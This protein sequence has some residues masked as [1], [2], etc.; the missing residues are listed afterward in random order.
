M[1]TGFLLGG[2]MAIWR[3]KKYGVKKMDVVYAACFAAGGGFLGAK[4][5]AILTFIPQMAAGK[6]S[7]LDLLTGGFVFYGGLIGGIGGLF[8]YVKIY[9]CKVI[10]YF[11]IFAPS[12]PLGHAVGR[13]GCFFA[14][15]CYGM[16]LPAGS[17]F[18]LIYPEWYARYGTPVGTP[19][20]PMQLIEA[21]SL[22]VLYA[23]L[24]ILFYRTKR[25]GISLFTYIFAYGILRFVLE[26]FR[27]DLIRGIGG[28]LSTSQWI[29]LALI[30]C[31]TVALVLL[32]LSEHKKNKRSGT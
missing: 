1:V 14:G 2:F 25:S 6:V 9:K 20:L 15:C 5:L 18:S 10:Q 16:E 7:I 31:A 28:G 22:L 4:L 17:T 30:V 13:M 8:L 24:E 12:V 11:D 3:G 29:S 23:V 19:L 32:Y 27:G 26:F 21:F